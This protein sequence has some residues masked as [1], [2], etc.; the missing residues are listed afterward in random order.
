MNEFIIFIVRSTCPFCLILCGLVIP[1]IL[2]GEYVSI[3]RFPQF[4]TILRYFQTVS[5]L[6]SQTSSLFVVVIG[7]TIKYCIYTARTKLMYRSF[8]LRCIALTLENLNNDDLGLWNHVTWFTGVSE[9]PA[10]SIFTE[11]TCLNFPSRCVYRQFKKL[12][13]VKHN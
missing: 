8:V 12:R 2:I 7:W 10:V 6:C 1:V 5:S 9:E 11:G 4:L 13:T 3:A